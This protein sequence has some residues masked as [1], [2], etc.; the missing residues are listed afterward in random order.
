M[1][2]WYRSLKL[3]IRNYLLVVL[4][5]LTDLLCQSETYS[6][7][8]VLRALHRTDKKYF[9]KLSSC[10]PG[11][12]LLI[13]CKELEVIQEGDT[14]KIP[15]GAR[16]DELFSATNQNFTD[17]PDPE[18]VLI[19]RLA[20]ITLSP[21]IFGTYSHILSTNLMVCTGLT[22]ISLSVCNP[23][24]ESDHRKVIKVMSLNWIIII[25]T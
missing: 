1:R 8:I 7:R 23:L 21:S 25:K 9:A 4:E 5:H 11:D 19:N 24:H 3:F 2:N 13:D 22:I 10:I 12:H 15:L 20:G 18:I 6:F 14:L 17:S 16:S